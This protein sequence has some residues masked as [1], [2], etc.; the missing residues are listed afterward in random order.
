MRFTSS[1]WETGG[2]CIG[3]AGWRGGSGQ[4]EREYP[5]GSACAL[6]AIID[7]AEY[8]DASRDM[9]RQAIVEG[10][11]RG[12]ISRSEIANE[13]KRPDLDPWLRQNL[14]SA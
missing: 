3:K 12:L 8:G 6:R 14:Q 10:K 2:R 9:L 7:V 11:S 5:E 4:V 13:L 1:H